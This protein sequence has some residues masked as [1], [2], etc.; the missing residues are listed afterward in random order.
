MRTFSKRREL[1]PRNLMQCQLERALGKRSSEGTAQNSSIHPARRLCTRAFCGSSTATATPRKLRTGSNVTCGWLATDPCAT[2]ASK[3]ANVWCSWMAHSLVALPL[4]PS[5]EL[6]VALRSRF[7]VLTL[8]QT[9]ISRCGLPQSQQR[10]SRF[11]SRSY[12]ARQTWMVFCRQCNS[13]KKLRRTWHISGSMSNTGGSK[14][15]RTRRISLHL[16]SKPDSGS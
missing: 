9:M 12:Q 13:V 5:K 8:N 6:L 14:W 10:S 4:S 3:R 1:A 16:L 7:S 15:V 11:G 2:G